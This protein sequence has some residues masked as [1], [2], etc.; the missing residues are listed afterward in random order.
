MLIENE[1][2]FTPNYPNQF[3]FRLSLFSGVA[4]SNRSTGIPVPVFPVS[5][6]F[7]RAGIPVREIVDFP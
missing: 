5:R 7:S 2:L 4:F 6:N 3:I 1:A